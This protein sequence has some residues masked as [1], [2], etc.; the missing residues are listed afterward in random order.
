VVLGVVAVI[1][2]IIAIAA[3]YVETFTDE[4]DF[5]RTLGNGGFYVGVVCASLVAAYVFFA[6]RGQGED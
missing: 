2:W 6:D 3:G 4:S 5:I 1:G